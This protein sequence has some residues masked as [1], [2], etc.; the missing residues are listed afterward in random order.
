MSS[1]EEKQVQEWDTFFTRCMRDHVDFNAFPKEVDKLYNRTPLPDQSIFEAWARQRNGGTHVRDRL[2]CYFELMVQSGILTDTGVLRCISLSLKATIV[3]QE[4]AAPRTRP[5]KQTIEATVIERLT[6]QM[7][8]RVDTNTTTA[9][10]IATL[11]VA[12]PLIVLLS[13]FTAILEGVAT[14]TGPA[15]DIG[16]ALGQ[17]VGAYINELSRFGLLTCSSGGPP[18]GISL[19]FS[20][21]G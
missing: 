21:M 4:K 9:T 6:F 20:H 1:K 7:I 15:L 5:P 14:L 11:R 17:Y 19:S 2:L 13:R 12:K 16:N 8:Q 10:R 3:S 18:K